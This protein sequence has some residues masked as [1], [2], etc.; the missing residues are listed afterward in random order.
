MTKQKG[1][2]HIAVL[3]VTIVIAIALVAV[4][5][6]YKTEREKTNTNTVQ[7]NTNTVTNKATNTG[8]N[9]N[10]NINTN[11]VADEMAD[12]KTYT[13]EAYSFSFKYPTDWK[14]EEPSQ[15]EMVNG[16]VVSLRSPATEEL[17]QEEKIDLGYSYDLVVSF[18]SNIKNES[19]RGGSWEGQ[20]NYT[21][22]ADYFTDKNAVKHKTGEITVNGQTAY[23]VSIGGAG[24]NYGVMIEHNGIYQLSFE[25]TWDKSKFS[26][27]G[28]QILSTFQFTNET[29]GW[30]TYTNSAI[31]YTVKY[32]TDWTVEETDE[33]SQIVNGQIVKYITITNP[34]TEHSLHIGVRKTGDTQTD[35]WA[36]TG[37]G[38]GDFQAG[39]TVVIAGIQVQTTELVYQGKAVEIFY[40]PLEHATQP[41]AIGG[42][43]V[44]AFFS[45]MTGDATDL[46]LSTDYQTA[47]TI[48]STLTFSK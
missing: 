43:D 2:I 7:T 46:T 39:S 3:V 21:D 48:L 37:I 23:E 40:S 31:G 6:W 20:R 28:S 14:L 18:W 41:V 1:Y 15:A 5:W 16:V 17:L 34:S 24:L 27:I 25:T 42:Y 44:S 9:A 19:A 35:I 22:L 45:N 36:R 33:S 47:N 13:N 11:T 32:P 12:W 10:A 38:A 26:S 30:K 4:A 29:A 8:T